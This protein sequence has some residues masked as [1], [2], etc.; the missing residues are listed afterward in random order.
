M[1]DLEEDVVEAGAVVIVEDSEVVDLVGT[2]VD[3][4]T[5]ED[6]EDEV[7]FYILSL[8]HVC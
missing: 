2:V 5:V 6:E 8:P 7:R 3:L 1:E 4:E